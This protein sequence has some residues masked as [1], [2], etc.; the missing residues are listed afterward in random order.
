VYGFDE[1]FVN[2]FKKNVENVTVEEARKTIAKHFPKDNLQFVLI[3]KAAALRD[4]V[5]KY[6]EVSGKDIK[7]DG[8]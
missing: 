1:S 5:R 8:F 2:N 4:Q 7:S 6:G 3:G